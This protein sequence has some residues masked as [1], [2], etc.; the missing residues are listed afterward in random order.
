MQEKNEKEIKEAKKKLIDL[1]L[2]LK[3][4]KLEDVKI[5][6]INII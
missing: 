1:Y 6:I 4:R 3:P 5:N 2:I